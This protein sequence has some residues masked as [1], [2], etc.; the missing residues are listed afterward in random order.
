MCDFELPLEVLASVRRS[1]RAEGARA[2]GRRDLATAFNEFEQIRRNVL[3]H[4][5]ER[6]WKSRDDATAVCDCDRNTAQ[7]SPKSVSRFQR[8]ATLTLR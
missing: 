2:D 1:Q 8:L 7:A 6:L 5:T 4:R 3:M